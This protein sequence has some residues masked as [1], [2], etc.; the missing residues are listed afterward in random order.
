[1]VK[2]SCELRSNSNLPRWRII[3]DEKC[4]N[5]LCMLVTYLRNKVIF[6]RHPFTHTLHGRLVTCNKTYYNLNALIYLE[7]VKL[8]SKIILEF[9]LSRV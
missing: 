7:W 9:F 2:F 3:W 4:C 8:Q 1:M 6:P 5:I